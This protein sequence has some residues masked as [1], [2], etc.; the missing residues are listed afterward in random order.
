MRDGAFMAL[1]LTSGGENSSTLFWSNFLWSG[2]ECSTD[3]H[4]P[5]ERDLQR[6]ASK[7][8]Q[9]LTMKTDHPLHHLQHDCVSHHDLTRDTLQVWV[10]NQ[11]HSLATSV[12]ALILVSAL[13][14]DVLGHFLG[15]SWGV[16]VHFSHFI[17]HGRPAEHIWT[18]SSPFRT[19]LVCVDHWRHRVVL[20]GRTERENVSRIRSITSSTR[21]FCCYLAPSPPFR[22]IFNRRSHQPHIINPS[23]PSWISCPRRRWSLVVFCLG[24]FFFERF[25][26]KCRNS[27]KFGNWSSHLDVKLIYSHFAFMHFQI[28]WFSWAGSSHWSPVSGVVAWVCLLHPWTAAAAVGVPEGFATLKV[29]KKMGTLKM[30]FACAMSGHGLMMA[31][32]WKEPLLVVY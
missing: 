32:H 29:L 26:F 28:S 30:S 11:P 17:D 15:V 25:F 21:P 2:W 20:A 19:Q 9:D 3:R 27:M 7:T 13:A 5:H 6:K 22:H 14:H 1:Q 4:S 31:R 10:L 18:L 23:G 24:S 16:Q 12:E 8:T